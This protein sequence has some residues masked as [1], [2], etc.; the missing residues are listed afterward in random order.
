MLLLSWSGRVA[1]RCSSCWC[2]SEVKPLQ[3]SQSS[4]TLHGYRPLLNL[5]LRLQEGY[6]QRLKPECPKIN[7]RSPKPGT[8]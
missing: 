5:I 4:R 3:L 6:N 1:G 8:P 7:P 2:T